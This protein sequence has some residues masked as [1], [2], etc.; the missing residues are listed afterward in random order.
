MQEYDGGM[1]KI[2]ETVSA[3]FAFTAMIAYFYWLF[4]GQI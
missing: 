4:T 3:I 1:G 2:Y